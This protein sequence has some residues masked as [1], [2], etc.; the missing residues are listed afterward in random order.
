MLPPAISYKSSIVQQADQMPPQL[1]CLLPASGRSCA[2]A[3]SNCISAATARSDA[4]YKLCAVA[5]APPENPHR[6]FSCSYQVN[7]RSSAHSPSWKELRPFCSFGDQDIGIIIPDI[8]YWTA[9]LYLVEYNVNRSIMNGYIN[10]I[11]CI[12]YSS[13]QKQFHEMI[14]LP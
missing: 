5:A 11:I 12:R 13:S 9:A 14:M 7:V 1:I 8:A 6:S 4:A 2:H 3:P 10:R